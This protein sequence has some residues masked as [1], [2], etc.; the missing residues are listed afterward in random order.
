MN[1]EVSD[2]SIS[3]NHLPSPEPDNRG[4][5]TGPGKGIEENKVTLLEN[6]DLVVHMRF[7]AV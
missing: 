2:S 4:S 1:D 7:I 6:E 3:R 5:A